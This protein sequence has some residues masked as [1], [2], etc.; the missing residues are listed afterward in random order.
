M[1]IDLRR[2]LRAAVEYRLEYGPFPAPIK[3]SQYKS[4]YIHNIGCGGLM[5][6]ADEPL[7]AGQQLILKIHLPGWRQEDGDLVEAHG[8]E[9]EATLTA[10]AEVTR[11]DRDSAGGSWTVGVRFLGRVIS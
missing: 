10:I 4:S 5:F 2:Y 11:C 1:V 8:D 6:S 3:D 7:A 9:F